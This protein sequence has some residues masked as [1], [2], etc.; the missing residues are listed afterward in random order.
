VSAGSPEGGTAHH[1]TDE[2]ESAMPEPMPHNPRMT[3]TF[4][5]E[6][7]EGTVLR[8][9]QRCRAVI[10]WDDDD[11]L[12]IRCNERRHPHRIDEWECGHDDAEGVVVVRLDSGADGEVTFALTDEW[13]PMLLRMGL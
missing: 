7:V 2:Q 11:D 4:G 9:V 13:S 10:G 3:F 12:A 8:A 1:G 5:D 6:T